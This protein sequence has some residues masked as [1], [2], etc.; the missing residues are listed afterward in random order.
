MKVDEFVERIE[1]ESK[2]KPED[3]MRFFFIEP[4]TFPDTYFNQET[5]TLESSLVTEL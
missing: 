3:Y 5:S 2:K 1:E 4:N